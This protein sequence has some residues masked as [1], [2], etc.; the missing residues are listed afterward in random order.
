VALLFVAAAISFWILSSKRQPAEPSPELESSQVSTPGQTGAALGSSFGDASVSVLTS[1]FSERF[2]RSAFV[3]PAAAAD[4]VLRLLILGD[5]QARSWAP[6]ALAHLQ[7][8][9]AESSGPWA[10]VRV[11]LSL[12]A[13]T[14]W[15]AAEA[16][17]FLEQGGW[18]S[19]RPELVLVAVGWHDG[20]RPRGKEV[21][22]RDAASERLGGLARLAVFRDRGADEHNFYL[23]RG[24]G[25]LPVE[26]LS[27]RHHLELMDG[28]ALRAAE[29]GTAVLYVEQPA[30]HARRERRVFATT[31]ARPQ[32]WLA[33]VFSL[34]QRDDV[35]A[36]F[37]RDSVFELSPAGA[38]QVGRYVGLGAAPAVLGIGRP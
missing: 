24:L 35:E 2:V 4:G 32:P 25:P 1:E 17:N 37:A 23:R 26:H 5:E 10:K 28:I 33:T 30:R 22:P 16:W 19:E 38:E 20:V 13:E 21:P 36:L 11:E 27:P 14:G 6:S 18:D 15:T 7:R 3:L 8:R 31:A 12:K 9:L 34:E 29:R